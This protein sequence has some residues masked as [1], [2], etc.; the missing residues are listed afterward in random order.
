MDRF[1]VQYTLKEQ[2]RGKKEKEKQQYEGVS[3]L[4]LEYNGGTGAWV[5]IAS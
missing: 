2:F 5:E 4:S 1:D 3:Q